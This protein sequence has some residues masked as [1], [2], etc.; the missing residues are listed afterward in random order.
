MTFRRQNL[1]TLHQS[2]AILIKTVA[3][4]QD[5]T[6]VPDN[7]VIWLPFLFMVNWL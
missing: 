7:Q 1:T 3:S 4:M 2:T 6:V 5:A